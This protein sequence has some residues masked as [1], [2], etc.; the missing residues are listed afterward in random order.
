VIRPPALSTRKSRY[1]PVKGQGGTTHACEG[2][3]FRRA[4]FAEGRGRAMS[5]V[6]RYNTLTKSAWLRSSE[7]FT[8]IGVPLPGVLSPHSKVET[9][10][11][12]SKIL[13]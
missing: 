3:N 7:Y 8:E 5:G 6:L 2:K 11:R 13:A 12:I 10:D 1:G 9:L 4:F